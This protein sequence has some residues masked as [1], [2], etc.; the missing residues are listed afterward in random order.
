MPSYIRTTLPLPAHGLLLQPRDRQI[1]SAAYRYRLLTSEHIRLLHFPTAT[2]R[3][4]QERLRRLYEHRYLERLFVPSVMGGSTQP[5]WPP[6]QPIYTLGKASI[7]IVAGDLAIVG[8]ELSKRVSR[9]PSPLALI[10]HLTVAHLLV[11]LEVACRAQ[12]TIQL[13]SAEAETLL[14][15]KLKKQ[16]SKVRGAVMPDGAFTLAASVAPTSLT[17]LVEIVRADIRGGNER[18]REKLARYVELNRTGFFRDAFGIERLRAVLIA[19]T[20]NDRAENLRRLTVK[21]TH[22]RNLFWFGV[23]EERR[24][25]GRCHSIFAPQTVLMLPWQ[26]VDTGSLT[27]LDALKSRTQT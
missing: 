16:G 20:S 7:P 3:A 12:S 4:A 13:V 8:E 15:A 18:L 19:T 23:Y 9:R 1:L 17:F 26:T 5:A 21:L 24:H 6:R 14:W 27:L 25:D 22:G 10:H 2:L 11:A